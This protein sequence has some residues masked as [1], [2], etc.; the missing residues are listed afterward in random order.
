MARIEARS[1]SAGTWRRLKKVPLR[2]PARFEV[3]QGSFDLYP[4]AEAGQAA[5]GGNDPVAWVEKTDRV[6]GVGPAYRPGSSGATQKIGDLAIGAGLAVGNPAQLPPDLMLELRAFGI[7]LQV[8][9]ATVSAE[10][11]HNLGLDRHA[12]VPTPYHFAG[13]AFSQLGRRTVF[14]EKKSHHPSRRVYG[15]EERSQG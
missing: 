3:E 15:G 14:G 13:E 12:S 6:G 5:I 7:D 1:V 9:D 10:I 4:A 2:G 8:E 11:F